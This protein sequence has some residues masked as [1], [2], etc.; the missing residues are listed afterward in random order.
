[1]LRI[2]RGPTVSTRIL[3]LLPKHERP[4]ILAIRNTRLTS[5]K[6]RQHPIPILVASLLIPNPNVVIV[7]KQNIMI[8]KNNAKLMGNNARSAT[9]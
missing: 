4:Q 6:A 1:M 9:K 3:R 7:A 2:G 8:A 5:G